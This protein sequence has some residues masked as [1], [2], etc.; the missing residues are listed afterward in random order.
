[1]PWKEGAAPTE[2]DPEGSTI[3]H[4]EW[5]VISPALEGECA[6][7]KAVVRNTDLAEQFDIRGT[8]RSPSRDGMLR[9]AS[10]VG[11]KGESIHG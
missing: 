7:E 3:I 10:G 1:M 4:Y 11:R 9:P 6:I 8:S 2:T 5:P